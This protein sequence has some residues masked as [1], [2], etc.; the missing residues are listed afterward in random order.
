MNLLRGIVTPVVGA[1]TEPVRGISKA[2]ICFR[3]RL[4]FGYIAYLD[5]LIKIGYLL[6]YLKTKL[7]ILHY[8]VSFFLDDFFPQKDND[9]SSVR[10]LIIVNERETFTKDDVGL[11]IHVVKRAIKVSVPLCTYIE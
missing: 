4:S 7:I 5:T 10:Y 2:D 1:G 9:S 6:L 8:Q 11:K 3:G